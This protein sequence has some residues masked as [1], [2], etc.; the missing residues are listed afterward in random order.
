MANPS[1]RK[2]HRILH[3]GMAQVDCELYDVLANM[4]KATELIE[5]HRGDLDL[6]I[7]PELSLTGYSVGEKFHSV[8]LRLDNPDL[9]RVMI[10]AKEITV[11]VG[12]IEETPTFQFYN[13]LLFFR[14]GQIAAKHRNI[15]LPNI[16]FSYV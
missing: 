5:A 4:A 12:V 15:C 3:V 8:A 16:G 9:K 11:G 10:A 14:D 2:T 7:F 6:L 13:K 1:A